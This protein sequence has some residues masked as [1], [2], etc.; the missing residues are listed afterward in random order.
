MFL[1]ATLVMAGAAAYSWLR[2][3]R[4][5]SRARAAADWL[6]RCGRIRLTMSRE[7]LL[8]LM[9]PPSSEADEADGRRTVLSFAHPGFQ[10]PPR[11]WLDKRRGRVDE[12][13]CNAHMKGAMTP[14]KWAAVDAYEAYLRRISQEQ[15]A[16]P[17]TAAP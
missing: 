1:A 5:I 8:F 14:E 11:A 6:A 17:Q 2:L 16:L 3:D 13:V 15:E 7:E 4:S 9:G 10:T 12:V